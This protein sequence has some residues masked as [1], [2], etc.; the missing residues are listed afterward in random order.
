MSENVRYEEGEDAYGVIGEVRRGGAEGKAD[1]FPLEPVDRPEDEGNGKSSDPYSRYRIVD[2]EI[3]GEAHSR[4]NGNG[5][6][7]AHGIRGRS[8]H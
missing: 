5:A 8:F 4:S 6:H 7:R 1:F 2:S 3:P